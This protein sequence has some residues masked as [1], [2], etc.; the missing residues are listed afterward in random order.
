MS[1]MTTFDEYRAVGFTDA[2]AALLARDSSA[3]STLSHGMLETLRAILAAVEGTNTRLDRLDGRVERLNERVGR[4]EEHLR[5]S[6]GM[7]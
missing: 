5:T 6:P 7:N 4:I 3:A 1:P 2:Q